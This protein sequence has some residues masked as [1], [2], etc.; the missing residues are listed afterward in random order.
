MVNAAV[1]VN[2]IR[3]TRVYKLRDDVKSV[4]VLRRGAEN[5]MRDISPEQTWARKRDL[6][7]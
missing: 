2:S 6:S 4:E 7:L 3:R 1:V 5:L